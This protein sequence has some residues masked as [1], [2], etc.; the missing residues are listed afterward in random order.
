[1]IGGLRQL[2]TAYSEPDNHVGLIFSGFVDWRASS[3][4]AGRYL[5]GAVGAF[6]AL[7][8]VGATGVAG[9]GTAVGSA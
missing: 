4:I 7:P 2:L 9:A 3:T 1:M 5:L 6:G 8:P